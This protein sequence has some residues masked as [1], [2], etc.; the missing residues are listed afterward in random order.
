MA[1]GANQAPSY[2]VLPPKGK[3]FSYTQ[4]RNTEE[5]QLGRAVTHLNDDS[6]KRNQ[7]NSSKLVLSTAALQACVA[8]C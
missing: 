8:V 2:W 5:I 3:T 1:V 7:G 4:Q 6:K